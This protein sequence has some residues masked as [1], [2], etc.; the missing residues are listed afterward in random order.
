MRQR[1]KDKRYRD[2]VDKG[3]MATQSLPLPV[4]KDYKPNTPKPIMQAVKIIVE[5]AGGEIKT[6]AFETLPK[7]IRRH[8][9]AK[10]ETMG[11][12]DGI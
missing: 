8:I 10:L 11:K 3:R 4:K 5:T 1:Q 6:I 2:G 12:K 7:Q 9:M